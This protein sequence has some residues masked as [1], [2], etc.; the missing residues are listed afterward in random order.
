MEDKKYEF[1]G[2]VEISTEEYRDLMKAAIE[3]EHQAS[4]YR[5]KY[6]SEESKVKDLNEKLGNLE[7]AISHYRD[8]VNS[9]EDIK[10]EYKLYLKSKEI[11]N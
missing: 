2:K 3:N 10:V 11:D 7:K 8:F 5:S 9:N 4:D 1:N 6:W